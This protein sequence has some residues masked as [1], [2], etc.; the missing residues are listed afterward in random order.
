MSEGKISNSLISR[1]AN[2]KVY[3]FGGEAVLFVF[4]L[5]VLLFFKHKYVLYL[6]LTSYAFAIYLRLTKSD[7][8]K[9]MK[10]VRR[11]FS[12]NRKKVRRKTY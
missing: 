6:L 10:G 12:G 11:I 5:I 8:I 3:L 1:Y 7:L 9:F 2:K 4:F